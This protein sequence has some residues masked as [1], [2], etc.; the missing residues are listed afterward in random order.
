MSDSGAGSVRIMLDPLEYG[1]DL[2]IHGLVSLGLITDTLRHMNND[3]PV[4]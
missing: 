4:N 2:I 1:Y 3:S